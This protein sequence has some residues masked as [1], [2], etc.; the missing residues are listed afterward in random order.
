LTYLL[1]QDRFPWVPD[2]NTTFSKLKYS[3]T[4]ASILALLEFS[5]PFTLEIDASE[6]GI[7]AVLSQDQH[8]IAYFSKKITDMMQRQ[9]AYTREFFAI[10]EAIT[11]FKHYLLGH[12]FTIK[13]D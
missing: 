2:A 1:K 9:P 5:K 4:Q 3:I 7:N 13:T 8:P 6:V 11:K 12:N 10:T